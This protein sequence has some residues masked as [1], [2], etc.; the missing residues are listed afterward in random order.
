MSAKGARGGN[1][2]LVSLYNKLY[3]NLRDDPGE[4]PEEFDGE[5]VYPESL[6]PSQSNRIG[7]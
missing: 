7:G 4:I 6:I 1:K 5:D 3:G 2:E